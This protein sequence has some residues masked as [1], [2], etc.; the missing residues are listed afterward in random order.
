MGA[1]LVAPGKLARL[2]RDLRGLRK[3]GERR[4]H[5][6]EESPSY[7]RLL[8]SEFAATGAIRG[9]VYYS[10]R[11]NAV[12]AR[13]ACLRALLGDLATLACQRLV[14]ESRES[15]DK[16]DRKTIYEA[17]RSASALETMT[18]EHMKPYEEPLLWPADGLIWAYG[19]GGD[20]RRRTESMIEKV[21]DTDL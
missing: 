21:I 16:H 20:W 15:R 11:K 4:I 19:A 5:F 17:V 10:V 14:I 18:Y 12:Q 1:V 13:E 2:R 7:R 9:R 6:H 3:T 8:L